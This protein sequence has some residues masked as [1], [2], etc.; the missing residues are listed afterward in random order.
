MVVQ[1]FSV[2]APDSDGDMV[3]ELVVAGENPSGYE[4]RLISLQSVFRTAKGTLFA[5]AGHDEEV[6]LGPGEDYLVKVQA[7][8]LNANFGGPEPR[9][10]KCEVAATLYRQECFRLGEMPVPDRVGLVGRLDKRV[11]SSCLGKDVTVLVLRGTLRDEDL[12]ELDI[13]C[14]LRNATDALIEHLALKVELL[15]DDDTVI[16]A[17]LGT[18]ALTPGAAR[19][20][21]TEMRP[22]RTGK[23]KR[24][25]LKLFLYAYIPVAQQSCQAT[26]SRE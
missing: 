18:L 1:Q 6:R 7:D 22:L 21:A 26:A 17:S 2:M 8:C 24:A 15:D 23:L 25:R 12:V 11:D 9:N 4:A 19:V 14:G 20:L 5:E 3:T 13:R 16:D 10:L